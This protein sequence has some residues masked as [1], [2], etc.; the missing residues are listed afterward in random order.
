M[1]DVNPL[2]QTQ[3]R[4]VG[5]AYTMRFIPFRQD[6]AGPNAPNRGQIQVQAMEECPPGH[7]LV[8]DSRGDRARCLCR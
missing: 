5:I 1:Q 7:V 6:K 3:A 8:V 4:M 2:R